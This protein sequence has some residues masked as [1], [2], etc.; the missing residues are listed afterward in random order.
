MKKIFLFVA[1]FLLLICE[2]AMAS[3]ELFE[4]KDNGKFSVDVPDG[5]STQVIS[6]G[7]KLKSNDS[8]NIL[9]IQFLPATNTTPQALSKDLA[10]QVKM[11]IKKETSNKRTSRL[12]GAIQELPAS[13]L[14]TKIGPIIILS[15]QAGTDTTTMKQIYDSIK[16]VEEKYIDVEAGPIWSNEH[17][18]TRCPEVLEEWLKEHPDTNAVWSG[19][20]TTTVYGEMSVCGI[21]T[22]TK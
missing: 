2:Q 11:S 20:W 21:R 15:S 17:A 8:K 14:A 5:W 1:V 22:W 10:K 7:C 3:K 9:S 12:E 4:L 16:Y 13:I 18:Q 19:N 6:Q